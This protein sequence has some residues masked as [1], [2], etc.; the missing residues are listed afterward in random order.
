[1]ERPEDIKHFSEAELIQLAAEI[2]AFLVDTVSKTGGHFGANLGVVELTIAL[3]KVLNSPRDRIIWDVGHQAYVHKILT[4]RKSAFPTLRK[5]KGMAGFPKRSESPHDMF[6]VGHAS[7]SLSAGLGMA[8]ARDLSGEDYHV[9]CVIGDGALTGGMAMEALNHAGHLGTKLLVIL[10]DNE[11]SIAENVGALSK[12]LTRLRTDPTYSRTKAEIEQMLRRVPA[13]GPR[14][15]KTLERV[16]DSVRHLV[17]PGQ[18]F[19]GFGFKYLGPVDGHDLPVL[20]NV[21]EDAKLLRGPVLI[22]LVTQKGKGYA[23]A[24]NAPDKFHAWPSAPKAKAAPSYTS[25]FSETLI[26]IASEDP[27]VVA[28]TAAMP[29]GTGLDKFAKVHPSRCF[30]V[31]IA[32]QHATTFCG[33]LAASGKRPVF[34]VYSTF[35]QRA[36]DQV[37][38][39]ICIQNLPV[40]FA[41]D[42]AGIVGPDGETHQG[43]FDIAYLRTVPNMTV[44]MPKDENELRHMLWTALHL[45][46]PSAVRYPRADG[47]GVDCSEPLCEL[48]VGQAEVLQ[49]GDDLAIL[50]LGPMVQVAT[51][52]A[53]ELETEHG[54][55]AAVVNMRFVKPID[56]ALILSLSDRQLPM[57]TIE[58][59]SLAGGFGSAVLEVLADHGRS[60]EVLRKGIPD[61]FV[62]HGSRSELLAQLGLTKEALVADALRIVADRK[63]KRY[64]A[65]R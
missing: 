16:K 24:E 28:V 22:H 30:D 29:G 52:A 63:R 1:M 47:L 49:D 46:G 26:Q 11:M 23:S 61:H 8:V 62:E 41:V 14:L 27:R 51:E 5:F 2:R 37:I 59:A 25:V 10:N 34:A 57:V 55:S 9:A 44:M 12:Y 19:E 15:T 21:L 56:E 65:T 20:I 13:I 7:T 53:Q 38:H 36:Y 6:G 31:G 3:H 39:D 35:L 43:V 54:I 18:L 32:E 42:R 17:V 45:E 4:G 60:A 48:P 58:E 33:G 64:S 40:V 50:A